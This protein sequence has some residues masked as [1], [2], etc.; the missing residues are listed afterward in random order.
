MNSICPK[1]Y[2]HMYLLCDQC[3]QEA[4]T[5]SEH[6][7]KMIDASDRRER[8]ELARELYPGL[9]SAPWSEGYSYEELAEQ[10]FMAADAFIK[11]R[12]EER[13]K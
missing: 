7:Q 8:E 5:S 9:L 3:Q 13:R 10:A 6:V 4:G 11:V 2:E 1:H 12:D